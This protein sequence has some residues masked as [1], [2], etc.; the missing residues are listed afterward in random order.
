MNLQ[1]L[2]KK[3]Q[4]FIHIATSQ[5]I[6]DGKTDD[7]IKVL[8]EE[9]LPTIIEQQKKGLTARGIYGAPSEWAKQQSQIAEQATDE[10]NDN[11]WLMWL[12]SSLLILALLGFINGGMNLL[13]SGSQYGILTFLTIGFGVGAGIYLMYHFIYRHMGKDGKERP[14]FWKALLFLGVTTIA[15]AGIFLLAALI[16]AAINPTLSP[17]ATI[18]VGA[19]AFG[20]R[21]LL[22]KKYNIRNAMQPAR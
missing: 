20:L 15:W 12:D 7:E 21:Y 6:K 5:L 9:I 13:K 19:V 18:F 11:P 3:N 17:I 14:S 1:E 8:L 22:K 16:P 4:E 2:T 10:T